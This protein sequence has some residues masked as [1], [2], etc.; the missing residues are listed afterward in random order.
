MIEAARRLHRLFDEGGDLRVAREI[1]FDEAGFSAEPR[2]GCFA[3]RDVDVGD[4]DMAA[5]ADERLGDGLPD[6]RGA[7]RNDGR[8][9]VQ[10]PHVQA[11]LLLA[12][13]AGYRR[14]FFESVCLPP[15]R[16]VRRTIQI[17]R[18]IGVWGER[19]L[20]PFRFTRSVLGPHLSAGGFR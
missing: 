4:D 10:S 20:S 9:A 1:A 19:T 13:G 5:I 7:A 11:S 2:G 18:E 17:A 3:V 15:I 16:F 8:F 14:S 6:E 12:F